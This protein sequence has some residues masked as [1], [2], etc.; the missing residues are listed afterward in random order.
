ML[1]RTKVRVMVLRLVLTVA[2]I[3]ATA[4]PKQALACC[5]GGGHCAQTTSSTF[6]P[7]RYGTCSLGNYQCAYEEYKCEATTQCLYCV[8]V[9]G[10]CCGNGKC[11]SYS[12]EGFANCN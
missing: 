2:A 6:N 4:I 12:F 8:Q 11:C 9:Q 10:T 3:M 7:P 1:L 5:G